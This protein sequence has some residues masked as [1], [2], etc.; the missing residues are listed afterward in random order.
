MPQARQSLRN[1]GKLRK[2]QSVFCFEVGFVCLVGRVVVVLWFWL[3]SAGEEL[4][5]GAASRTATLRRRRG[6]GGPPGAVTS[7]GDFI[8]AAGREQVG[9]VFNGAC[10]RR[11][12]REAAPGRS[13]CLPAPLLLSALSAARRRELRRRAVSLWR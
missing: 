1:H 8:R 10:G 9:A 7:D 3:F 5:G 11:P 6:P 4:S 13:W 12:G 2:L